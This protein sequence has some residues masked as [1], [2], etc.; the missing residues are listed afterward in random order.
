[1]QVDIKS[2]LD[3][4]IEKK[5]EQ[6]LEAMAE[7]AAARI[8]EETLKASVTQQQPL[9]FSW[10]EPAVVEPPKPRIKRPRPNGHNALISNAHKSRSKLPGKDTII[11]RVFSVAHE[12]LEAGPVHRIELTKAVADLMGVDVYGVSRHVTHLIE[13]G[14]LTVVKEQP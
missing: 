11:Y 13:R 10:S 12:L 5:V 4:L 14:L 6:R 3:A 8:V 1:M 9:P 7:A 2:A